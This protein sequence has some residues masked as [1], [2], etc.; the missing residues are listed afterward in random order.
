MTN[1]P[2]LLHREEFEKIL[3][4]YKVSNRSRQVL[5]TTPFVALS[6][7]AGGGRNTII[8]YMAERMDYAFVISDTTRPPKLRDGRMEENGVDYYFR[9]E[10]EFLSELKNGDFIE[11]EL[12]HNQQVSG[13]S[14]REV[15]RIVST[16][17]IPVHDYEFGGT[18]AIALAK[19][20]ATIIGLLPPSY[21]EWIRRLSSRETMSEVELHN[22]L[23]TA[24]RVLDNMLSKPYFSLVVNDE[25]ETCAVTID[26]IVKN[27]RDAIDTSAARRTAQEILERLRKAL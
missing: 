23:T 21:D 11:A 7:L 6:G 4:D 27:G 9:N 13:T 18:N 25:I 26:Q 16:G 12:I 14:I 3:H 19:P 22:R 24:E 2:K 1:S 10:E 15:E 5:S 8:R 20:D 17:K